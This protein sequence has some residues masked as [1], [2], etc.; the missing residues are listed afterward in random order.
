MKKVI[1]ASKNPVK[2]HSVKVAFERMFPELD[3]SFEWVSVASWVSEQ[4]MTNS[5]TFNWAKNRA[6]NIKNLYIDADYYVG[7]EWGVEKIW[8]DMECFAW[9]VV[10]SKTYAWKAKSSTFFLPPSLVQLLD[11]WIELWDA[12]DMVFGTIN[13]KQK[14]WTVGK[15]TWDVITRTDYYIEPTMLAL[16]PHKNTAIYHKN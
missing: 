4:P 1:I 11:Q 10:A 8:N 5:E 13:S 6:E 15:L 12:D 14:S 3:F 9:V 2:I 7:I 16:I